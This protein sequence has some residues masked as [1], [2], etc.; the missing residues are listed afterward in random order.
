MT[1]L[2]GYKPAAAFHF[3][4][5]VV[6][7]R[8]SIFMDGIFSQKIFILDNDLFSL[9]INQQQLNNIGCNNVTAFSDEVAFV[10]KLK[11]QPR[12]IFLDYRTNPQK[13]LRVLR[14]VKR[15]QPET[16]VIF[17]TGR[18]GVLE[19]LYSLNYGAF[20]YII[21]DKNYIAAKK[22]VL[23]NIEQIEILIYKNPKNR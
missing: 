3:G 5:K 21:K 11:E 19:A 12:I 6:F 23:Q 20:E 17:I 1:V 15:V 8:E 14:T 16:Y 22:Q 9:A 18:S 10:K 4:T 13:G 7:T 2:P